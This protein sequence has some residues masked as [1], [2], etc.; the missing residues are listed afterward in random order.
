MIQFKCSKCGEE[1]EAPVS[2]AGNAL[3]CPKCGLHEKVPSRRK[4]AIRRFAQVTIAA[5]VLAA[6]AFI[7]GELNAR[8]RLKRTVVELELKCSDMEKDL[9]EVKGDLKRKFGTPA[10]EHDARCMAAAITLERY[11]YATMIIKMLIE[12]IVTLDWSVHS[13]G[14]ETVAAVAEKQIEVMEAY[15]RDLSMPDDEDV[16]EAY[17]K[18]LEAVVSVRQKAQSVLEFRKRHPGIWLLNDNYDFNSKRFY[19]FEGP[20][21]D[22]SGWTGELRR[23]KLPE[24]TDATLWI[25]MGKTHPEEFTK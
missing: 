1:M 20:C 5:I 14:P 4:E 25:Y 18:T 24:L 23:K 13:N 17:N 22:A 10:N 19:G 12:D 21:Q 11:S 6:V 16:T 3:K 7:V 15:L 2:E 9:N 8:H